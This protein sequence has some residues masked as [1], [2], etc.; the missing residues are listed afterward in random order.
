LLSAVFLGLYDIAKKSSVKDNAVPPVLLWNVVTAA[1]IWV[2]PI[3]WGWLRG[4]QSGDDWISQ[5]CQLTPRVH[6]LLAVKSALVGTSW[7]FALFALKGLPLS[8]ATPIRATSPLWT[9]LLAVVLMGE[10]PAAMQYAG[11]AIVM[12]AVLLFSRVGL[13]E[14]I[15]FHRDRHVTLMV[16][17]TLLGAISALY[18]KYLLQSEG[19][20][21]TA[22]QAWFSIYLVPVMLPLTV[23]WWRRE[24]VQTPF[25]WRWSIPLIAIFLLV[26]DF[27]YFTAVAYED[28]MISVISPL[29]RASVMIPFFFGIVRL[30]E[31]NWRAKTPCIVFMLLGVYLIS[32][33]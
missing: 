26:A 28:A 21:P 2:L 5:L 9:I 30:K 1:S 25:H 14:G 11:I 32:R 22:V 3:T 24:R 31:K 33:T 27:A 6:G 12:V 10:S 7:T 19:L 8:I 4:D 18:D 20:A 13:R 17:A 15:R 23:R 29:R 16:I